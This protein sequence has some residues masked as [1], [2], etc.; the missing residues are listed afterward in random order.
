MWY[1]YGV[2]KTGDARIR[3]GKFP[4]NKRDEQSQESDLTIIE[5]DEESSVRVLQMVMDVLQSHEELD[6]HFQGMTSESRFK[7]ATS[8]M[9]NHD[10]QG[11]PEPVLRWRLER[12]FEVH[13]NP[14]IAAH[15]FSASSSQCI[16]AYRSGLFIPCA[17]T[18]HPVNEGIIKRNN[19]I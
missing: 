9:N 12:Y 5:P 2:T 14:A 19:K 11:L 17:M 4:M 1:H 16:E 7:T 3:K 6:E 10:L 13:H 8:L 15:H 18:T